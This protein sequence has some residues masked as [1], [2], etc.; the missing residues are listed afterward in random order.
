MTLDFE[1]ERI[2][3]RPDYPPTPVGLAVRYPDATK[4]YFSWGHPSGNNCTLRE[5]R[6]WLLDLWRGEDPLLFFHAKFDLS[7]CYEKLDLRPLPW[8]R[9]HDAMFLAFLADPHAKDLGLKPLAED[10]LDWPPDEQDA[11]TEYVWDNRRELVAKY[12]HKITNAKKGPYSA[13]AWIAKCPA[14]V[15]HPYAIG[16]VDRTFGLFEHLYPLIVE[17]GMSVS[18]DRERRVLP[19][20]M[21]NERDGMHVA[22]KALRKD[23]PLLRD[24][25][26]RADDLLRAK[27]GRPDLNIDADAQLAEAL[28]ANEIIDEDDWTYTAPTNAHP[29]GQKSVS[30]VNLTYDMF[31]DEEIGHLFFYRNRL[32][33]ALS[34]FLE[35][36]LIQAEARGGVISTNWNQ[37]RG[38]GGGA[39]TGRPSTKNPNFLNVAKKFDATYD[40]PRGN[41]F[42]LEPLPFVR[43]YVKPDPGGIFIHRDFDG[44]EMRVFAH[45]EDGDLLAAYQENPKLDPH[46]WVGDE[47]IDLTG[48]ELGRTK[49]KNMNFLGLYGGGAPAAALQMG[50]TLAKAREYLAYHNEA[51][52]G[53]KVLNDAITEI[54][55]S[56]E[57]IRTIGGRLYFV[58][59][60]RIVK[61]RMQSF[62]YKLINVIC[63]GSA[64][65]LTK[66]AMIRWHEHPKREARFLLA[67]Y[68][69]IN[70]SADTGDEVRQMR[71][72]TEC[73]ESVSDCMDLLMTT[74]GKMGLNWGS[75]KECA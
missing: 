37:T 59:P 18:Y 47:I 44:Q 3:N 15:V 8:E 6:A 61:G 14:G 34:T 30:K 1:S 65:D 49:V 64:A 7:I 27:L 56:G 74:S 48:I 71:I 28:S 58:E 51:L 32:T 10:L 17:N 62:L 4:D 16:D 12:G 66:E 19:V 33:T 60:S 36:W 50:T 46:K 57:P 24:S 41:R 72:L 2:E 5:V 68:D 45:Y 21:E 70:G 54:I 63:Q 20:F 13:G 75:L 31:L 39:R 38:E 73:M 40:M 42:K 53:R 69:E 23:V 43:K 11:M 55:R 26:D 29:T 22:L 67:V 25:L 52:P 35:P 9:V